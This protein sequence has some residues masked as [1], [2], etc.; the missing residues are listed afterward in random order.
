MAS[1]PRPRPTARR[2]GARDVRLARLLVE[3]RRR[4]GLSQREVAALAGV[5]WA[6]VADA[7]RG[8]DVRRSTLLGLLRALPAMGARRLLAR[9]DV[10]PAGCCRAAWS[11]WRDV[12]GFSARRV[13][14]RVHVNGAGPRR[15]ELHVEAVRLAREGPAGT[16]ALH[17]LARAVYRGTPARLAASLPHRLGLGETT[18][19]IA[20]GPVEHVLVLR[21]AA[22]DAVSYRRTDVVASEP[23]ETCAVSLTPG[24]PVEEIVLVARFPPGSAPPGAFTARASAAGLADGAGVGGETAASAPAV[25]WDAA[26]SEATLRLSWPVPHVT[27]ELAWT[28][29]GSVV[30]APA[31]EPPAGASLP[32][33]LRAARARASL[34]RRQLAA[35]MVTSPATLSGCESGLDVRRRTLQGLLACLP[36]LRAEHLLP[37][38]EPARALRVAEV[39][40][41]FAAL[42]GVEADEERKRVVIARDGTASA[43]YVT[44]GLRWTGPCSRDLCVGYGTSPLAA[45]D[46]PRPESIRLLPG[47]ADPGA[48]LRTRLLHLADG[49]LIH[50]LAFSPEAAARGVSFERRVRLG[51]AFAVRAAG[52]RG[53]R[54]PAGRPWEG[55]TLQSVWPSRRLV[56]EVVYPR[57]L[58]PEEVRALA[59]PALAQPPVSD[60]DLLARLHPRGVARDLTGGRARLE[61]ADPLPGIR[62][63]LTW[64]LPG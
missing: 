12:N 43:V 3:A 28:R 60:A 5:G 54:G 4:A 50:Q 41:L 46:T 20:D 7:E 2:A 49:R 25:T 18:I 32:V 38:D 62:Y 31:W 29:G 51:D 34:S 26:P 6:T 42:A 30:A 23:H 19:V 40:E 11:F 33:V 22:E 9:G 64:P 8:S 59:W 47:T 21:A 35:R 16:E 13:T 24:Y 57:G 10:P 44:R 48:A 15:A 45:G 39:A 56:I 36:H 17:A 55:T 1:N 58:A 52:G 61:V 63:G 14:Y 37:E 27:H 53:R